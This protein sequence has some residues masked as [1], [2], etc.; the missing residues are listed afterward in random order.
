MR[1]ERIGWHW[2]GRHVMDPSL[3]HLSCHAVI[4][5]HYSPSM[6]HQGTQSMQDTSD[7]RFP[8]P[9]IFPSV[10]KHT[11]HVRHPLSQHSL[12]AEGSTCVQSTWLYWK[13]VWHRFS[14]GGGRSYLLI[15]EK[16]SQEGRLAH[17]LAS[18]CNPNLLTTLDCMRNAGH[19][20]AQQNKK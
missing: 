12:L 15:S 4:S 17:T 2:K 9:K 19:L 13:Q 11:T 8:V 18:W 6:S 1:D 14:C 20:L 7:L 5:L 3:P 10:T 16:R